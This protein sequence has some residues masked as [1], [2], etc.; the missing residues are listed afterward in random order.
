MLAGTLPERA[1]RLVR[2][3][4]TMHQSE[5]EENWRRARAEQLLEPIAS[6]P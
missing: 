3:W 6:L 1:M 2:E 5:L 4:A